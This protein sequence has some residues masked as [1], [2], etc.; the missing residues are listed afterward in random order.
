LNESKRVLAATSGNYLDRMESFLSKHDNASLE[1]MARDEN[2]DYTIDIDWK[3]PEKETCDI[4]ENTV[5]SVKN[6]LYRRARQSRRPA[7]E[8]PPWK[9]YV[10]VDEEKHIPSVIHSGKF[11]TSIQNIHGYADDDY[12]IQRLHE[13]QLKTLNSLHERKAKFLVKEATR[14]KEQETELLQNIDSLHK[15]VD[16]AEQVFV[17]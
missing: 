3:I 2:D 12:T 15:K 5:V 16:I 14:V 9:K 7:E 11:E 13:K 10:R 4:G 6:Q 1:E 17:K 8:R